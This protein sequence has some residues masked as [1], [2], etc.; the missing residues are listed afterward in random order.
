SMPL[1][2]NSRPKSYDYLMN[3]Q[4]K[5]KR[6]TNPTRLAGIFCALHFIAVVFCVICLFTSYSSLSTFFPIFFLAPIF[7]IICFVFTIKG[8][9]QNEKKLWIAFL[10]INIILFISWVP[11]Y[12][13]TGMK[14]VYGGILQG[15]VDQAQEKAT[16]ENAKSVMPE[17]NLALHTKET[18]NSDFNYFDDDGEIARKFVSMD[19]SYLGNYNGFGYGSTYFSLSDD[20]TVTFAEDFSGVSVEAKVGFFIGY[21]EGVSSYSINQ[22]DGNELKRM[23]DDKVSEQKN[24]YESKEA[25]EKAT[26]TLSAALAAMNEGNPVFECTLLDKR[27]E[28]GLTRQKD[29]DKVI[30]SALQELVPSATTPSE[31]NNLTYD[32]GF[33]YE[34]LSKCNYY[35]CYHQKEKC[36]RIVKSYVDPFGSSRSLSVCYLLEAEEGNH[37]MEVADRMVREKEAFT[38]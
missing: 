11:I 13:M 29:T 33:Y 35:L 23:I 26:T 21:G 24:A 25:E 4:I 20:I 19:F 17:K 18:E 36:L 8:K 1:L 9:K 15:V 34:P 12:S 28:V 6:K 22:E 3:E 16:I 31:V 37:L 38:T 5:E 7:A 32:S 10:A 2:T 30:L 14:L 27:Y